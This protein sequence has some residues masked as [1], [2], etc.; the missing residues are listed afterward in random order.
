LLISLFNYIRDYII[1][2]QAQVRNPMIKIN[3]F[4]FLPFTDFHL[5]PFGYEYYAGTYL[6]YN[7]TLYESYYRWSFGNIDGKSYGLGMCIS[8]MIQYHSIRF[9]AGFDLWKQGFNLLEYERDSTLY[10]EKIFSGKIYLK[11][12][13]QINKTFSLFGQ[14]SYK[15]DGFLLGNPMKKGFGA[16]VGLS[17]YL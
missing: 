15:G 16:K 2:G 4:S 11:T 12:F 6:K 8:N 3:S 1:L 13:Y 14:V 5:S 17:F 7:K 10:R 9:D